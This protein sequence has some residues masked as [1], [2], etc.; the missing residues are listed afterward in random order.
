MTRQTYHAGCV[1]AGTIGI[2]I[3]GRSGSGKSALA[4]EL[5]YSAHAMGNY[6]ALVSDDRTC[7]ERR[8]NLLV[9]FAPETLQGL[10]EVRGIGIRSKA[11]EAEAV[12]RLVVD[13]VPGEELERLP[14]NPF[15]AEVLEE[16]A[17]PRLAAPAG[18][19]RTAQ[20]MVRW[21]IKELFPKTPSYI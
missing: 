10:I 7:L 2:L 19:T 18:D 1:V 8:G 12:V 4:D 9:A 3:Q 11:F 20:R 13:L 5:L 14:D 15:P 17:I 16:L 21:A 6:A